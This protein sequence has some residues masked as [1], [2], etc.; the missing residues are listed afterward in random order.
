MP[1]LRCAVAIV[2]LL[3]CAACATRSDGDVRRLT[4]A[5][6]IA[7]EIDAAQS[8]WLAVWREQ[9]R[10]RAA[11]RKRRREECE[12]TGSCLEMITVTGS[13][14]NPADMIT[15]VQEA[16]V[17]EG[18][19]VKKRGRLLMVLRHGRLHVLDTG[20]SV[21]PRLARIATHAVV[22]DAEAGD[23]WYDEILLFEG[24]AILLG[25]NHQV[26]A[27]ELF[28][29]SLDGAGALTRRGRWRILADDY[30]MTDDVGA[31]VRGDA[32]LLG[33]SMGV[34]ALL[35]GRWP[36]AVPLDEEGRA[37]E[38][39]AVDLLP[40]GELWMLDDLHD[41]PRAQIAL[42]CSLDG[43]LAQGFGCRGRGLIANEDAV[44]YTG[45]SGS[46]VVDHA[47]Y[48]HAYRG[49][50]HDP[51]GLRDW[52]APPNWHY[53][54]EVPVTDYRSRVVDLGVQD[55]A[56]PRVVTITGRVAERYNLRESAAGL[57][58]LTQAWSAPDGHEWRLH[59]I[60]RPG[61][62]TTGER[63]E[64][65][66]RGPGTPLRW[67]YDDPSLWIQQNVDVASGP[68]VPVLVRQPL[69]GAPATS[70]TLP[71]YPQRME[72]M[73]DQLLLLATSE[74][75]VE[76][77]AGLEAYT[78][79]RA[80]AAPGAYVSFDGVIAELFG[81]L[82]S[83]NTVAWRDG[84]ALVGIP[85]RPPAVLDFED[86]GDAADAG[87]RPADMLV[88]RSIAGRLELAGIVDLQQVAA[89]CAVDCMEW[90]GAARFFGFDD[91][92]FALSDDLVK[93]L[94]VRDG[95]VIERAA[96]DLRGP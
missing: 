2:V 53:R 37:D 80:T 28:V 54:G 69:D 52:N 33:L 22:G 85:V 65:A 59:S 73:Q 32:L 84:S 94:T 42:Q 24:G 23:L 41:R 82:A 88:L 20:T 15:N 77:Q 27:A 18:D 64:L 87:D 8:Q 63:A 6:R 1:Y 58:V 21:E 9:E 72:F 43:L 91:R 13:R 34:N 51:Q 30:F 67:R 10:L 81:R 90:Y 76:E 70:L 75:D 61:T 11:A 92:A 25:Y 31:R 78:V 93:E 26:G 16:G 56:P 79:V 89:A 96:V 40:R 45:A 62:G 39:R 50:G 17:D 29:F 44:R 71:F 60:A 55:G 3:S 38:A 66:A 49:H 12:T 47:W 86:A 68:D 7:A 19:I 57:Y 74:S 36:R 48:A 5:R 4:D 83:V 35:D 14:I 95:R 46:Y